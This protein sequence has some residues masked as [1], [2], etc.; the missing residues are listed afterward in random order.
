LLRATAADL[1][2]KSLET[3]WK[4]ENLP[5]NSTRQILD[6]FEDEGYV[7]VRGLLSWE[8][9]LQPVV[10]EYEQVLDR[11]V[12]QW[13]AAGRL[14][15]LH[16]DLPFGDRLI[17]ATREARLPYDQ[18]FDISLP[19]Q[20]ITEQTPI[21]T[22]PAVFDLLRNDRLLDQVTEFLGEEIY[23]N[24]VQHT[25]VKIPEHLIPEEVRTGLTIQVACHQDSGVVTADADETSMLTVW[26]PMTSAT[27]ENGCLA[28][29]PESHRKGLELHCP[30]RNP[31]IIDQTCIPD[32]L[33]DQD[34]VPLVMEPGD[35][36]FMHRRTIHCGLVNRS[37][38]IRWSFDLRYQPIGE[39]TG[40]PWFPGF[41]ARSKAHPETEL[42]DASAWAA[43][44]HAARRKLAHSDEVAF[45]RWQQ[46]DPRCA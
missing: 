18:E 25:R 14:A 1:P 44:W 36:I 42:H 27:V 46:G 17:Q 15:T 13:H 33:I 7:V 41:V 5:M 31:L 19:Q 9:D 40:R 22:G 10:H 20:N 11:L 21:H 3:I 16:S 12:H 43:S 29:I 8:E 35:V 32:Q 34:L 28:V 30:S 26:F 37:D 23:S 45:N 38:K 4:Q 24:P 39:P 6:Q 2:V